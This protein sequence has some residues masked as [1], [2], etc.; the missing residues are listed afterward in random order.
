MRENRRLAEQLA[1]YAGILSNEQ[2]HGEF[3]FGDIVGEIAG[4]ARGARAGRAGGAD[5]VDRAAARRDRHRQ[6]AGRARDPRQQRRARREPFVRVNCAALRPACSRPSCSA[7]RRAR[8]PA[9]WR[10]GCGRF[11]LADGG[12]LFLDEIGDLPLDVQ[13]KLLRVLQEREFERVGGSET[14]KVDVRVVVGDA[15]RPREADRA[16]G[17]SA[18]TSTTGSTSFPIALPPLRERARRHR[19]CWPSTSSQK[20]ARRRG[21]PRARPRR[22]RAGRAARLR[23]AGQRARARERHRARADPGARRRDHRGRPRLHAP[24]A[25]AARGPRAAPPVGDRR[26]RAP[27]TAAGRLAERLHEQER[28]AIVAAIDKRAGQH[29]P[30]RA[31]ARHQPLDALLPAAQARAR[32]P[33]ADEGRAAQSAWRRSSGTACRA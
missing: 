33:A 16:T 13:V 6:G 32:A 5:V 19:R 12:T 2:L 22:R 28:T 30:R 26:R 7:T 23:L 18:R 31:R 8:S 9:R 1:E 11:E 17:R 21:K 15:P 24:A 14:I 25:P 27:P 20:F 4:A 3:D 29:R 10:G